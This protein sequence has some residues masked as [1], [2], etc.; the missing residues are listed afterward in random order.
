MTD[1]RKYY[2][3]EEI[4]QIKKYNIQQNT[5]IQITDFGAG[6]DGKVQKT[7]TLKSVARQSAIPK[8][9][10]ELLFKVVEHY[11]PKNILELGTCIGI[12]T[13]YM[14]AAKTDIPTI[15]IEGDN[16]LAKIASENFSK[17]PKPLQNIQQ[18][19]GNFDD[20]L[21]NVL[22]NLNEVGLAFI[23]GNHRKE[24]T[25]QYFHQILE[26]CTSA[27]ILIFD[28]IYWS[29]EMGEAWEEIKNHP[30]VKLTID[31]Y[32]MGFVFFVEEKKAVEH[33]QLYF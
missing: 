1:K 3:F 30:K 10:G 7:R 25:L 4:A 24:P 16:N 13:L 12:G 5:K 11:Q 19:I 9:Y 20:V 17:Y 32:R 15:T 14:A 33:F 23:D 31:L 8:K 2:A 28:D 27:S 18:V 29:E 6:S 22:S 21:L 26:K